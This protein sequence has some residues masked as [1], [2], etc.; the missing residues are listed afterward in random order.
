MNE[1]DSIGQ[2]V[3]IRIMANAVCMVTGLIAGSYLVI[4]DHPYF[5][6]LAILLGFAVW[7]VPDS[8][9]TTQ[10]KEDGSLRAEERRPPA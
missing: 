2:T 9:E 6:L 3:R 4:N 1:N 5:G 8:E 10:V 7:T